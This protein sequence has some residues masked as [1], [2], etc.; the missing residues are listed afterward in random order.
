MFDAKATTFAVTD[1]KLYV[2]VLILSTQGNTKLLQQL[3]S[4][5]KRTT[6]WNKYQSKVT[7]EAPNP[8]LDYLINPSFQWV[9]RRFILSFVNNTD[10][11]VHTEYYFTTIEIKDY[12]VIIDGQNFFDQPVKNDLRTYS[13]IK[14]TATSQ[15]DDYKS[16]CLLYYNYFNKYYKITAKDLSKQQAL[17]ADPKAT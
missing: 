13:N 2:P 15:G 8:Y 4:S 6:N 3:K 17:D 10:R 5:F 7:T 14:K 12:N 11:T 1:T 16:R 9:N